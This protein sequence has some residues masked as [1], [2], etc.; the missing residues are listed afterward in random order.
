MIDDVTPA[1]RALALLNVFGPDAHSAGEKQW[2]LDQLARVL[3]GADY[4]TWRADRP[5]W[6]NG[7]KL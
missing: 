4:D 7:A 1:E 5:D 2:L 3:T 6:S